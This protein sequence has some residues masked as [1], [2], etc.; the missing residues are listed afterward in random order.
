MFCWFGHKYQP[1]P[2]LWDG[3]AGLEVHTDLEQC[4]RCGT[5]RPLPGAYAWLADV[6]LSDQGSRGFGSG[7]SVLNNER[8]LKLLIAETVEALRD[9]KRQQELWCR[10]DGLDTTR[11]LSAL[12]KWES[13][14]A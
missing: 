5:C 8:E 14:D 13:S 6:Y 3:E 1:L 10:G 2:Q 4:S 9:L 12:E 11:V 7:G